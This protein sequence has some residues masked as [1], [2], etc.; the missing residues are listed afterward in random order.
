[1]LERFPMPLLPFTAHRNQSTHFFCLLAGPRLDGYS[2]T[3]VAT[4]Y[5]GL[6]SGVIPAP[7]TFLCHRSYCWCWCCC[8]LRLFFGLHLM[9]Q[10]DKTEEI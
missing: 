4:A 9:S 7:S 6:F 3:P 2:T 5:L 1:M 10:L 8:Y